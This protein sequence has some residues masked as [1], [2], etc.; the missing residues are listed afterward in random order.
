MIKVLI[1]D[2]H[3]MFRQGLR[4]LFEME[5]DI[6]VVGEARDGLEVQELA[7]VLEPDIILMDI[8]MPGTDGVE[9]TRQ[10]LKRR[11]EQAVIILTMFRE[12][13]HVYQAIN[14]GARGYVLKDADSVDVLRALRSVADGGSVLD[15]AMTN[16][17]FQQFK[18]MSEKSEKHN[19]EGLTN[20]EL[21]ILALI[22]NGDSNRVIGEKL[23]LSEKTIKN[24]I[25]SIF[26]KLQTSDRTHAAVYAIQHGL[27]GQ[28][29]T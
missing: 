26:Q 19:P 20:R 8:N 4:M 29:V 16:K 6:K 3:K 18:Q 28:P 12:D 1:A 24:Y 25:T 17:V 2:D 11:P 15:A 7:V 13:E 23:F 27:I 14:A 5:S 10:V 22:A 9:A 21:E